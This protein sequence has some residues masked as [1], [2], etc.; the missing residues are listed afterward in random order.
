MSA[1]ESPRDLYYELSAYTLSHPD[2]AF[3]HQFVVDAFAAQ[4]ADEET[5]PITLTFALIGLYLHIEK[6]FSGRQVQRVHTLLAGGRKDWPRF[7]LP[8]NRGE[9]T[10]R[11]V[12]AAPP[13]PERDAAIEA[14]CTSVWQAYAASRATVVAILHRELG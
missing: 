8:Q 7:P 10:V 9:M 1:Q 3:I 6:H 13:G 11:D 14:W 5:K 12:L 4:S 2:P